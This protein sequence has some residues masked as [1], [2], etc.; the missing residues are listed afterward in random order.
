MKK[1]ALAALL[2]VAVAM[3]ALA[4]GGKVQT[5]TSKRVANP[6]TAVACNWCFT[7]GGDW[8][9]FSGQIVSVG[10]FPSERGGSCSGSNTGRSDSSP[11]LC[12][13]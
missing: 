3:P 10:N 2:S 6:Q 7:C 9:V 8:P 11:W 5:D 4:A 13:R 12:C 1:Y